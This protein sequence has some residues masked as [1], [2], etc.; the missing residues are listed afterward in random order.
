MTPKITVHQPVLNPSHPQG[1][2]ILK[3]GQKPQN[4]PKQSPAEARQKGLA[5]A[6]K[7]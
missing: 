2:R 6:S 1:V 7:S 4:G 3:T 5:T